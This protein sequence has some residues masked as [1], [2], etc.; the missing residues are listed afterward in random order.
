MLRAGSCSLTAYKLTP[1]GY[2]WGKS[3][4]REGASPQH[5]ERVQILLSDRFLGFFM[6]PSDSASF[7]RISQLQLREDGSIFMIIGASSRRRRSR[8][9]PTTCGII[10]LWASSTRRPCPT[11]SSWPHL[12]LFMM[13]DT[14]PT[15][16]STS[17]RWTGAATRRTSR[18]RL[19][20]PRELVSLGGAPTSTLTNG[21]WLVWGRGEARNGFVRAHGGH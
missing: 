5:Y 15:T 16:S 6:V 14:G 4:Q 18:T 1:Q 9:G 10:I 8:A 19:T 2:D 21:G 7:L 11:T 20:R 3:G 13:K 12:Y 17:R